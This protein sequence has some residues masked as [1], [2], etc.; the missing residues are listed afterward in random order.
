GAANRAPRARVRPRP[1]ATPAGCGPPRDGGPRPWGSWFATGQ[2]LL[3]L[4]RL[5]LPAVGVLRG[6]PGKVGAAG[7]AP[8]LSGKSALA[9]LVALLL[10]EGGLGIPGTVGGLSRRGS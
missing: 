1:C 7:P 9:A 5:R 10:L 2:H 6:A 4:L 8:L 3:A